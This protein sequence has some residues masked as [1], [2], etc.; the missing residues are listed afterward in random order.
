MQHDLKPC[1][2]GNDEPTVDRY[3]VGARLYFVE[4]RR[5][6]RCSETCDTEAEAIAAWNRRPTPAGDA[7]GIREALEWY[8]DKVGS[9]RKITSEGED[10]RA[11]LDKDGG[12]RARAALGDV[13]G[14]RPWSEQPAEGTVALLYRSAVAGCEHA[15]I[16]ARSAALDY[17]IAAFVDGEWIEPDT[18]HSD[19]GE[20]WRPLPTCWMAINAPE[21]HHG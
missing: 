18:S 13:A 1:K 7:V 10:A 6:Y 4:C 2:C 14:W 8:A 19:F 16:G 11:A 9:C 21:T 15:E 20:D 17:E 12:S 3:D 5:C